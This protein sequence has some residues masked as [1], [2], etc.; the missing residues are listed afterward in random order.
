[1]WV[2]ISSIDGSIPDPGVGAVLNP[3]AAES[4]FMVVLFLFPGELLDRLPEVMFIDA[5]NWLAKICAREVEVSIDQWARSAETKLS[6]GQLNKGF[7]M[8][9]VGLVDKKV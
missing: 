1:M 6:I 4:E 2:S 3:V 5:L 8:S 9:L 7:K